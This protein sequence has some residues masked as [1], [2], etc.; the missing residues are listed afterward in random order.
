MAPSSQEAKCKS[1]RRWS[2]IRILVV[3]ENPDALERCVGV[4]E[5]LEADVTPLTARSKAA[6]V[7]RDGQFQL[8]VLGDPGKGDEG[9]ATLERVRQV[10]GDLAVL[11]TVEAPDMDAA[12]RALR[13]GAVDYLAK[14]GSGAALLGAVQAAA[15]KKGLATSSERHILK[16]LGDNVRKRR[17]A[18]DLKLRH[19]AERAGLSMSLISQVERGRASPSMGSLARIAHALDV[20]VTELLEGVDGPRR[21][22]SESTV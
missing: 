9:L 4:L 14:D 19:V 3:D 11:L 21:V 17:S 15:Q 7:V 8:V 10:D 12:I 2:G 13:L 5:A 1:R 20:G 16:T 6:A 18:A 22:S